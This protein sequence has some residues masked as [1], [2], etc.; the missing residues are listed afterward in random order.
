MSEYFPP[1]ENSVELEMVDMVQSYT[2]RQAIKR[3]LRHLCGLYQLD[4]DEAAHEKWSTLS[5][6]TKLMVVRQALN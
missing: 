3:I 1:K 4:S 2:H 5:T 6:D